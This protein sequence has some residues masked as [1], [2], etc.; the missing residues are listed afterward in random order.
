[1]TDAITLMLDG[2]EVEARAGE[3]IWRASRCAIALPVQARYAEM[4]P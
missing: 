1:M 2:R 4:D 3:T